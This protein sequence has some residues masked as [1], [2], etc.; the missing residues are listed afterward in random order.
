MHRSIGDRLRIAPFLRY[1]KD[2]YLVVT[3]DGRLD[4]VQ[5][6]TRRATGS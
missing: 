5:T 2:P 1:D 3:D 4:Y 6:P